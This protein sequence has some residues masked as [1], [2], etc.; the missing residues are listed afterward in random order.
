MHRS[1]KKLTAGVAVA[2]GVWTI[3]ANPA[4]AQTPQIATDDPSILVDNVFILVCGALVIFMQAGFAMIKAGV[5]RAKNAAHVMLKNLLDFVITVTGFALIG[6]HIAFSGSGFFGFDWRWGGPLD[7]AATTSNLTMPIHLFFSVGFAAVTATIVSGA[8]AE[9]VRFK[10]YF[11]CAIGI[12]TLVYPIVVSWVWGG[13][14][15][16]T[17]STP[18]IDLAGSTVVHTTGGMAALVGAVILGPRIGRFDSNGNSLPI[19]GHNLPLATL[20]VFILLIGWF[21]FNAGSLLSADVQMGMVVAT[22]AIGGA[23]GGIGAAIASWLTVKTPDVTFIGNGVLGGLVAVTA[24]AAN[25]S[26]FGTALIGLVA[27][28]IAT[29]G[30]LLLDRRQID[31]PVGAIPVH[32]FCGVW[33]TLALGFFADPDA[34]PGGNGPAGALYGGGISQLV[35]Q[36][37]G[38]AAVTAFVVLTVGTM[39][40][41]LQSVEIMRVSPEIEAIG[42]DL[43]EHAMPAYNDDFVDYSAGDLNADLDSLVDDL[44]SR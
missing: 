30:V 20:G 36:I 35:S 37:I 17:M 39:F 41:V 9:R 21:G 12:S 31:D 2:A 23:T 28:V 13:G 1:I 6:Y 32:L 22:T 3:M 29:N 7:I 18:F 8:M 15:L 33:G 19:P 16:S 40:L 44:T 4:A 27:G 10:A 11:I 34:V 42:L 14:W 5:T 24:G 26:I 43:A 38:V 25:L